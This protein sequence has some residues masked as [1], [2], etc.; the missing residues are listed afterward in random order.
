MNLLG[1]FKKKES[2]LFS[3]KATSNIVNK[4]SVEANDYSDRLLESAEALL[5]S[6]EEDSVKRKE[7]A[8][9]LNELGF[10][11][12]KLVKEVKEA[13]AKKAETERIAKRLKE[14]K[15]AYPNYK[16]I[17]EDNL[18]NILVKRNMIIVKVSEFNGFVPEDNLLAIK[19][20][21]NKHPE[22][23]VY[24]TKKGLR[25]WDSHGEEMI[26]L[27]EFNTLTKEQHNPYP[28]QYRKLDS[29][30]EYIPLAQRQLE[31][32]VYD[33][34]VRQWKKKQETLYKYELSKKDRILSICCYQSETTKGK[35]GKAFSEPII[36]METNKFSD[37]GN[38]GYIIITAWGDDLQYDP[39][40]YN[41]LEIK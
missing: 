28:S 1:L 40:I 36:V 2:A 17:S 25:S 26:T 13:E 15:L 35:S 29:T 37:Y 41:D 16:Y 30:E 39:L 19:E 11:S 34:R 4:A 18:T 3:E 10:T 23:K 7:K 6:L 32:H 33:E 27:D 21:F 9:L 22:D 5:E 24:Y 31:S 38:K 8:N 12:S 14:A 20:F